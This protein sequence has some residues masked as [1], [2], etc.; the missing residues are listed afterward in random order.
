MTGFAKFPFDS[1]V[2]SEVSSQVSSSKFVTFFSAI[3][4]YWWSSK[5]YFN[6]R[7]MAQAVEL[8]EARFKQLVLE[9]VNSIPLDKVHRLCASN[10]K[11]VA[12]VLQSE[13]G[14]GN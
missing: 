10:R 5:N 9:S 1:F 11:Y 2:Y 13:A 6:K 12:Q 14:Q 3:E 7:V 8:T 4:K